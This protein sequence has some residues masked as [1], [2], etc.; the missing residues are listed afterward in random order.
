MPPAVVKRRLPAKPRELER[1][2]PARPSLPVSV[3]G[4]DFSLLIRTPRRMRIARGRI[5]VLS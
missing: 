4:E 3:Y 5:H 1:A 2:G